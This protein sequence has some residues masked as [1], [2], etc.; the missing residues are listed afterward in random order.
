MKRK[1]IKVIIFSALSVII[2][3]LAG[4][5]LIRGYWR[6][7]ESNLIQEGALHAQRS[8]CLNCHMPV[9]GKEI[10]NPHSR[11]GTV[12]SFA[13]GNL[14]MY[15]TEKDQVE[16]Y[17]KYGHIKGKELP[18]NQLIKMPPFEQRIDSDDIEEME[19]YV[20]AANNYDIPDEGKVADG[21]D[22]ALEYGCFSCHGIAGSGG[23]NNPDSFI[24]YIPG[25]RGSDYK[26][27]VN[28]DA[29]LDE[30]IQKG[31]I[32]RL[33]NNRAAR[34]FMERQAI[35]MPAYGKVL[36]PEQINNLK[37]YLSWQ[38]NH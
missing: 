17:I 34:Y 27:L 7:N 11:L 15:I 25:W 6:W 12:P 31:Y 38:R 35:T 10:K 5:C 2:L 3:L 4:P 30:W 36:T 22:N 29:E 26:E 20:L 8:G 14:M 19:A 28:N 21:F 32:D 37:V 16:E 1:W 9:G 24:G 18:A 13:G 23:M 33:Q